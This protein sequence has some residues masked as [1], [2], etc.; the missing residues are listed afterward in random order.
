M[1]IALAQRG[2]LNKKQLGVRAGLSSTSGTFGTYLGRLR[3]DGLILGSGDAISITQEGLNALGTYQPLPEG[4]ELLSYW[5]KELG[6]GGAG[7]ML[8]ALAEV[9][10]NPLSKGELGERAQ[11]SASSG[12]F[13]T[14]LGR[15]RTLELVEG[16]GELRAAREFFE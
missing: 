13:G 12:T 14:Y 9:Y 5:L 6:A 8:Q 4:Q 2:P 15:L 11:I 1:L 10:P 7:R 16:R 3:A